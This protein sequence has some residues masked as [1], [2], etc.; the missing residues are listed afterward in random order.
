MGRKDLLPRKL[1]S[2]K[3]PKN[4]R[5]IGD[6]ALAA[7]KAASIVSGTLARAG[8]LVPRGDAASGISDVLRRALKDILEA[9][10]A[11]GAK[12]GQGGAK[13]SRKEAAGGGIT[14]DGD[15]EARAGRTACTDRRPRS[16]DGEAP[17]APPACHRAVI[18]KVQASGL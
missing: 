3:V 5:R 14:P 13:R 8:V 11:S 10:Q 18:L 9:R 2:E 4:L 17:A 7:P 6:G 15:G 1:G 16:Q 12:A